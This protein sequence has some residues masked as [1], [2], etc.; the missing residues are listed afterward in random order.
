MRRF[1]EALGLPSNAPMPKQPNPP[2]AAQPPPAAPAP[3]APAPQRRPD[4]R[5]LGEPF[6]PF[7]GGPSLPS[8][9]R[10]R[11]MAVEPRPAPV[12]QPE[13][14]PSHAPSLA[15]S[16]APAPIPAMV[17][18]SEVAPSMEV[19]SLRAVE[20]AASGVESAA[21]MTPPKEAGTAGAQN[22]M[23]AGLKDQLRDPAALKRA[24]LLREI[25]GTPKGL[26]SWA[27]PS[28]LSL[29]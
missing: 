24:I 5:R 6:N 4:L 18:V 7:G 28:I 13:P 19:A 21:R 3:R 17:S 2:A 26:Q 25:L 14:S 27:S 20:T 8:P 29:P 1:M 9:L 16:L 11:K 23:A 12:S 15:P 22:E 10:R